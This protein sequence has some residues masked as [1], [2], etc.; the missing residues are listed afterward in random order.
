MK[1]SSRFALLFLAFALGCA[2]L[3]GCGESTTRISD[4]AGSPDHYRDRAVNVAGEVSQV[5]ELPLGITNVAAYRVSDG[6]G[7][8]WVVSHAGA[9]VVGDRVRI[10]GRVEPITALNVP[11]FGNILGSVIEEERRRRD[12]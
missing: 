3:A 8:I 10:K 5:Y 4:I 11:V 6:T 1:S 9:P 12:D 2:L 7:Q